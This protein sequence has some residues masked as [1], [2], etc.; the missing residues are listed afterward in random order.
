MVME[1]S[2]A[3]AQ[4]QGGLGQGS[5]SK[6]QRNTFGVILEVVEVTNGGNIAKICQIRHLKWVSFMQGMTPVPSVCGIL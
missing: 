6:E 5:D 2:P 4:G 1:V 3:S